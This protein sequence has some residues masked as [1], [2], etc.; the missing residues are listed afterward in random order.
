M[1]GGADVGVGVEGIK[2]GHKPGEDAVPGEGGGA[3]V[4]AVGKEDVDGHGD[5]VG[6]DHKAHHFPKCRHLEEEGVDQHPDQKHEPEEIRNNE[7]LTEGD[8]VIQGDVNGGIDV[9][10]THPLH[11]GEEK[12]E[13][14]PKQ[15]QLHMGKF[16]GVAVLE[17]EFPVIH[18]AH[19]LLP[20]YAA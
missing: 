5:G 6:A 14:R 8:M 13:N 3:E 2:P 18:R 9:A 1:E 7:P 16:R 11:K 20:F 4:L 17:A 19:R 10:H 15:Q 12:P